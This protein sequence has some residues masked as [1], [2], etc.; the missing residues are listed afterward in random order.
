MIIE[1]AASLLR[2]YPPSMTRECVS[3]EFSRRERISANVTWMWYEFMGSETKG[4]LTVECGKGRNEG[5]YTLRE[6]S[7]RSVDWS[8][9]RSIGL[10]LAVFPIMDSKIRRS[11]IPAPISPFSTHLTALINFTGRSLRLIETARQTRP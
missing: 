5:R 1:S 2:S 11:R 9:G 10:S 4:G 8:I 3:G 7:Y 6:R